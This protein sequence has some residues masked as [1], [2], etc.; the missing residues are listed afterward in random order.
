MNLY[1]LIYVYGYFCV[2][3]YGGGLSRF[4]QLL[5]SSGR[6]FCVATVRCGKTLVIH[7]NRVR[8][9]YIKVLLFLFVCLIVLLYLYTANFFGCIVLNVFN[10]N[11]RINSIIKLKFLLYLCK[12]A[13]ECL[14]VFE[15][16]Y[17]GQGAYL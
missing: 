5:H 1:F 7:D 9:R 8:R 2:C 12:F 16:L 17:C 10:L 3:M 11:W 14:F 6:L 13:Y 4:R 15:V